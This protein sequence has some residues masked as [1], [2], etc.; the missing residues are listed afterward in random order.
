MPIVRADIVAGPCPTPLPAVPATSA[1]ASVAATP[2]PLN[3]ITDVAGV[4]VGHRTVI[5]GDDGAHDAVRT[6]VTAIFP[7]EADPWTAPGLRRRR[8]SST[9][10]AS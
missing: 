6:G 3:A 9:A 7:H 4:R 1:S 5:R 2:G 10:T 8:T